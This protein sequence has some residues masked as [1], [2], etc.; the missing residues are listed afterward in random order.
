MRLLIDP[1]PR[2]AV[3]ADHVLSAS[4]A[5]SYGNHASKTSLTSLSCKYVAG[6]AW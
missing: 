1:A 6:F 2:F 4:Q 3:Y 5:R